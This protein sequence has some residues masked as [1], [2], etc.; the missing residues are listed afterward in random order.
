MIWVFFSILTG[1]SNAASEIL[2]GVVLTSSIV[3]YIISL[4]RTGIL[5]SVI[6]GILIFKEKNFKEVIIGSI[7]MFIGVLLITTP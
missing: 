4:K 2:I 1:F 7:I 5:F 6:I 3:P